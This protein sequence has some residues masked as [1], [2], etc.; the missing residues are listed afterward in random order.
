MTADANK[1]E[2]L[3]RVENHVIATAIVTGLAAHGIQASTTGD[4]TAAF[5]AHA[6]GDVQ[7]IVRHADLAKAQKVLIE[8]QQE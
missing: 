3:A 4:Y 2:I 5:A 8:L 6:P 7:V 1:P